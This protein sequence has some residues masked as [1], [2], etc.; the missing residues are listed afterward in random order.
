MA[1]YWTGSSFRCESNSPSQH[2]GIN[3]R[4]RTYIATEEPTFWDPFGSPWRV[5]YLRVDQSLVIKCP[6]PAIFLFT[7]QTAPKDIS[8]D[9]IYLGVIYIYTYIP[10]HPMFRL[11]QIGGFKVRVCTVLIY[12]RH[13]PFLGSY[14]GWWGVVFGATALPMWC[15]RLPDL[16]GPHGSTVAEAEPGWNCGGQ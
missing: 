10:L 1:G 5:L 11:C 3:G 7:V 13:M 16:M 2:I 6:F 14:V 4:R 9:E 15:P 12:S 8:N